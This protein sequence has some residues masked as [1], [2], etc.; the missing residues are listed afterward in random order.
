MSMKSVIASIGVIPL[1]EGER[2][3]VTTVTLT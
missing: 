2:E 1:K 3:R